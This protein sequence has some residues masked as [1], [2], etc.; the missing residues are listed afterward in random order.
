MKKITR[1]SALLCAGGLAGYALSNLFRPELPSITGTRK[2][3]G[4]STASMLNDASELSAT[5][6][7]KHV[8]IK[9]S[10]KNV[11]HESI[12]A[13]LKEAKQSNMPV[14]VGAARHSMGGQAIPRDGIAVTFDN[15]EVEVDSS[16][17][18][19]RVHAGARWLQIIKA[20]DTKGWSPTVTQANHDFGVA[21]TFSVN[22]HG[23]QVPFGPM[24]STVRAIRMIV[25]SGE[26]IECSRTQNQ[27]LFKHAMGGYGLIGIITDLDIEMVRNARLVPKLTQMPAE[28]FSDAFKSAVKDPSVKMAYG[29]MNVG[30]D[31]ILSHALLRTYIETDDQTN[32]PAASN[33][34]I[35]SRLSRKIYRAQ[36][37]NETMKSFR[38]WNETVLG[39]KLLSGELTRNSLTNEPV[40]TLEDRNPDRTDIIHEYF[41]SFDRFDEFLGICR[42]VIPA[43]FQELLNIT[44]RY[45]ATDEDSIL[46][47]ATSPRIAAVMSFSQEKTQRAESD[48]QRMTQELIEQV[49]DIGGTYYLPY[50]PHA[51]LAQL[52]RAYPGAQQFVSAKKS[53]DP[54]LLLRNNLWD[55]YLAKL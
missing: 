28:H 48:M 52:A 24:G 25:P 20:L 16:T 19:Y 39:P 32:L 10:Y 5:P 51:T 15:G 46:A 17:K 12:R 34:G 27:S 26:L 50:R 18:L 13:A 36:L 7:H 41:V 2:T 33:S 29:R 38:W 54:H 4:N 42:Q 49:L 35:V 40:K 22:A 30:R 11:I 53:Y 45:V 6:I 37:G 8:I 47:Y 21:A 23:W 3:V 1:R 43:S 14:N 31:Q 9:D 44:L 55:T